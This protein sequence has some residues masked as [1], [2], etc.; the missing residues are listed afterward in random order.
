MIMEPNENNHWQV[1]NLIR[2][3]WKAM[4][5][6]KFDDALKFW[7]QADEVFKKVRLPENHNDDEYHQYSNMGLLVNG[8]KDTLG[9]YGEVRKRK[10]E[11]TLSLMAGLAMALLVD[12]KADGVD[13][14]CKK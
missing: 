11:E 2:Q 8:T 9:I 6:K 4:L 10:R 7:G 5:D 14:I 13:F 1:V 12:D 3:C